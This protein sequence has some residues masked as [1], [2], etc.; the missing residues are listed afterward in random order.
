MKFQ[1]F[2]GKVNRCAKQFS[3]NSN[4]DRYSNMRPYVLVA[5][6]AQTDRVFVTCILINALNKVINANSG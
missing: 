3:E 5:E 2:K 4:N 6:P 1:E